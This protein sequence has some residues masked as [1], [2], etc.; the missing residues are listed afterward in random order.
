MLFKSS[1]LAEAV[2]VVG[3]I[4]DESVPIEGELAYFVQYDSYVSVKVM[5]GCIVSRDDA[6]LILPAEISED[7]RDLLCIFRT[8]FWHRK[9]FGIEV[10]AVL[11]WEIER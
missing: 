6:L 4:H 3:H 9:E 7:Q 5:N 11:D 2:A 1:M 10:I 8:G